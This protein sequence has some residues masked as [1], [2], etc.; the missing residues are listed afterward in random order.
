MDEQTSQPAE[1]AIDGTLDQ[2]PQD[3]TTTITRPEQQ[4]RVR[5]IGPYHLLEVIGRGG[6]GEIWLAEQKYPVRRR[7]ALKL[8]R[9][10]M[11]TR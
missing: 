11:D 3:P 7:V 4:K 1:P 6:M 10:G 2:D 9:A 5:A 8:I